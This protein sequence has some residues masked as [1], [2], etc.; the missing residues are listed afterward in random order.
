MADTQANTI[1]DLLIQALQSYNSNIDLSPGSR[2]YT[3]IITPIYDALS[4]DMFDTDIGDYLVTVLKE[5]YPTLELQEGDL[6]V[7][8]LVKP[9]QLLLEPLKREINL[10]RKRQS[11]RYPSEMTLSDAEDLAANF[12]VTRKLGSISRGTVRILFSSPTFLNVGDQVKFSTNTGLTFFPVVQQYISIDTITSQRVGNLYYADITVRSEAEGEQYNIEAGSIVIAEGVPNY[13]SVTN[14]F[15]FDTASNS[16]TASQLLQRVEKSLTERSLTS[17]RGIFARLMEEFQSIRNMQVIGYGDDEM[18]RD[19]LTGTSRGDLRASGIAFSVGRYLFMITG[20]E[21]NPDG[22]MVAAPGDKICLNFWKF[23]YPQSSVEHHEIADVIYHS[24][25]DIT[26]MPTFY[27][28]LLKD[29]PTQQSPVVG[30][31]PGVLPLLFTSI[32]SDPSI[33]ISGLPEG[34]YDEADDQTPFRVPSNQVHLGGRYDVWARPSSTEENISAL[35]IVKSQYILEDLI[36]Y[37]EGEPAPELVGKVPLNRLGTDYILRLSGANNLIP[38][39]V[40]RGSQSHT[41]GF[42]RE[43]DNSGQDLHVI[44]RTGSFIEGE[45]VTGLT[46]GN[47]ATIQSIIYHEPDKQAIGGVVTLT[48]QEFSGSFPVLDIFENYLIL[49]KNIEA[50]ADN[51]VAYTHTKTGVKNIFDPKFKVFPENADYATGLQTLIGSPIV[52]VPYNLNEYGVSIGNS[53]E[54]LNGEDRGRYSVTGVEIIGASTSNIILSEEMTRTNS[55]LK[56]VVFT[57]S[58]PFQA[59]L[60]RIKPSGMELNADTG[61]GYEI[62]YGKPVGA[63][64]LGAF[65]GSLGRYEGKNGFVLPNMGSEF[66]GPGALVTDLIKAFD[67]TAAAAFNGD[68]DDCISQGCKDCGDDIPIT[69]SVTVDGDPTTYTNIKFYITGA[70]SSDGQ[71]YLS[72]LRDWLKS[73]VDAWFRSHNSLYQGNADDLD[74]FI[75]LFAPIRLGEPTDPSEKIIKQFEMCLPKALFDGCNNT[76]MA[77]PEIQWDSEFASSSTFAEAITKF[78][79]GTIKAGVTALSYAQPGDTLKINEGANK[80]EYVIDKVLNIP[81]YNGDS[82]RT[83]S[84]VDEQG[85]SSVTTS[86]VPSKTY[87]FTLVFI[88]GTFPTEVLKGSATYFQQAIPDLQTVLPLMPAVVNN[89]ESRYVVDNDPINPPQLGDPVN[90]FDIIE[91]AYTAFF[92]VLNIQGLDLPEEVNIVPGNTLTKMVKTFFSSYKVGNRSTQ[93]TTRMLFQDAA[94]VT[95][96]S[97][98]KCSSISW[99]KQ[100]NSVPSIESDIIVLPIQDLSDTTVTVNYTLNSSQESTILSGT[101]GST[102]G[103]IESLEELAIALQE[104]LDPVAVFVRITANL[105]GGVINPGEPRYDNIGTLTVESLNGGSGAFLEVVANDY[106]GFGLL[107]FY[108]SS[109][110]AFQSIEVSKGLASVPVFNSMNFLIS[111]PQPNYFPTNELELRHSSA[112]SITTNQTNQLVLGNIYTVQVTDINGNS[113]TFQFQPLHRKVVQTYWQYLGITTISDHASVATFESANGTNQIAVNNLGLL[114]DGVGSYQIGNTTNETVE[115]HLQSY[116]NTPGTSIFSVVD[117]EEVARLNNQSNFDLAYRTIGSFFSQAFDVNSVESLFMNLD[118]FW[119]GQ[120]SGVEITASKD[121]GILNGGTKVEL[122]ADRGPFVIKNNTADWVVQRFG[123]NVLSDPDDRIP[124]VL[125][126]QTS[127]LNFIT[128]SGTQTVLETITSSYVR[129]TINQVTAGI[130]NIYP[131]SIMTAWVAWL[132]SL[133]AGPDRSCIF[134]LNSSGNILLCA[135]GSSLAVT[136]TNTNSVVLSVFDHLYGDGTV[137][138]E[139]PQHPSKVG[140]VPSDWEVAMTAVRSSLEEGVSGPDSAATT[141]HMDAHNGTR[142]SITQQAEERFLI[143]DIKN[144]EDYYTCI[145]PRRLANFSLELDDLPRDAVFTAHYTLAESTTM[146]FTESDGESALEAGVKT[147]DIVYVYEQVC[148]LDNSGLNTNPFSSHKDRVLHVKYDANLNKISLLTTAGTFLTPESATSSTIPEEDVVNVGDYVFF[149]DAGVSSRIISLSDTEAILDTSVSLPLQPAAIQYGKNGTVVEN[150][151]VAVAEYTFT[152]AD[153][154]NYLVV[155]G[156]SHPGVDGTYEIDSVVAGQATISETIENP[157]TNLHWLIVRPDFRDLEESSIGGFNE[158][159]GVTPIRIYRG[160]PASFVVAEINYFLNRLSSTVEIL[161]GDIDGGPRRG[162]KQPVKILRPS[163]YRMT[164]N[165]METQGQTSGLYYFDVPSTTLTPTYDLNIPENT[166]YTPIVNTLSMKGY[167][168]E[169]DNKAH[170]YSNRESCALV[171]DSSFIPKTLS[172]SVA[173]SQTPEQQSV[174]VTYESSDLLNQIQ[175]FLSNEVNRNLNSDPLVKHFLPSYVHLQVAGSVASA[176]A[177]DSIINYINGLEPTDSI[178]VSILEKFLHLNEVSIYDHPIFV[179]CI[180]HDLNRDIILTRTDNIIDDS[181]I[182]HEGTNRLT[183]FIAEPETIKIGGATDSLG[184]S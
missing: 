125:P 156:S 84:T 126:V 180:T 75:D 143:V 81:W 178:Q 122:I 110:G 164:A 101:L 117:I 11:A 142:F 108:G 129:N 83:E 98:R 54:I 21:D 36:L 55:S 63:Y 176:E 131:A 28:L 182:L 65:A 66:Q 149:E 69:C 3:E 174:G 105:G 30:A 179:H 77:I 92:Q 145:M 49:S 71:K 127:G 74:A 20:Y 168:L 64:A 167:T 136:H 24:Y 162:V 86:I 51:L 116:G 23:L 56:F 90:A 80:G 8:L 153:V 47:S 57:E 27:V 169:V 67:I 104:A 76:Y 144:T 173:N 52:T 93:Q 158:T 115:N 100:I 13:V 121:A 109:R 41:L 38:R 91:E 150:T 58:A 44:D 16:E 96:Y 170:V 114:I 7:D 119:N 137:P 113:V 82:V 146:G 130:A 31:L 25:G 72:D 184:V 10:L 45:T 112:V 12:F 139:E 5:E 68:M 26:N 161:Y 151:F 172:G 183:Y 39:E 1:R 50:E 9:L 89:I 177:T 111:S 102:A 53:I 19:I 29:M 35:S 140:P 128:D 95:V 32:F 6:I 152:Q 133:V 181:T 73:V 2:A 155:Y 124:A 4:P 48:S 159:R 14:P 79:A 141:L 107:G 163:E 97:P 134:T 148:V 147:G 135:T 37:A 18:I 99:K 106:T 85:N 138:Q 103:S 59:P 42:V 88:K 166:Q 46:S 60:V 123:G 22:L 132:N 160:T 17:R 87:V 78:L 165:Q 62:P 33:T 40:I 118:F 154:G 175:A 94:D 70:V 15:S 157:E 120:D 171:V 43:R 61:T 34:I